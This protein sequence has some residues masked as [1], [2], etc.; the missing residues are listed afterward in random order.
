MKPREGN[1]NQ[2]ERS[3]KRSESKPQ[4]TPHRD[5]DL[6]FRFLGKYAAVNVAPWHCVDFSKAR[7]KTLHYSNEDVEA[8]VGFTI[9]DHGSEI[10]EHADLRKE[11]VELFSKLRKERQTVQTFNQTIDR[12]QEIGADSAQI[13]SLKANAEANAYEFER[14]LIQGIHNP[15]AVCVEQ[16]G[17]KKLR[18]TFSETNW[19]GIPHLYYDVAMIEWPEPFRRAGTE[20]FMPMTRRESEKGTFGFFIG[21]QTYQFTIV[22]VSGKDAQFFSEQHFGL[23]NGA[24]ASFFDVCAD[25]RICYER[26]DMS[27]TATTRRIEEDD[28]AASND[29]HLGYTIGE[30]GVP[31]KTSGITAEAPPSTTVEPEPIKPDPIMNAGEADQLNER[32]QKPDKKDHRHVKDRDKKKPS[33]VKGQKMNPHSELVEADERLLDE[34]PVLAKVAVQLPETAPIGAD[35]FKS[36]LTKAGVS[37]VPIEGEAAVAP[38]TANSNKEASKA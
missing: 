11:N 5:L 13:I 26:D 21:A 2:N 35:V 17:R 28:A 7:V 32:G 15:G 6:E 38:P 19:D 20:V 24:H 18:V 1:R 34:A 29:Q 9:G 10:V 12:M 14:Q 31:I 33:P 37:G 36:A 22:S 30:I 23:R 3:E 4:Q 8:L 16:S 25:E 27:A